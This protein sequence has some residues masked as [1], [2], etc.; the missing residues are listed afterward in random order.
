M[1]KSNDNKRSSF[2]YTS[3][4]M[5][6]QRKDILFLIGNK[7]KECIKKGFE[8]E[9]AFMLKLESFGPTV[10]SG[11]GYASEGKNESSIQLQHTLSC[12][13]LHNGLKGFNT[14]VEMMAPVLEGR[15]S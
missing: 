2:L 15:T 7:G 11:E 6:V 14:N 10:M 8:K 9:R 13:M 12:H 4:G 5:G 1:N 3:F